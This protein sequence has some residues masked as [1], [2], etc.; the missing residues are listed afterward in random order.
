MYEIKKKN[1]ITSQAEDA[2]ETLIVPN[3]KMSKKAMT[4]DD[5]FLKFD[6]D[7]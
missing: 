7:Y 3:A 4:I 5:Q 1:P 2:C 6:L